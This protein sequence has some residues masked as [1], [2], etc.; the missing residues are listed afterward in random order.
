[1]AVVA[2][3]GVVALEYSSDSGSSYAAISGVTSFDW[4][5]INAEELD[6]TDFDS[7]DGMR[8]YVN[9]LKAAADGSIVLNYDPRDTTHMAL[10]SANGGA[11]IYLKAVMDDE[12][13]TFTA[14]VKG[15]STPAEVGGIL[16]AT[17]TIKLTGSPTYAATA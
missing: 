15:F 13:V 11:P 7:P 6:A 8:E 5:S 17:I 3:N 14:L 9:G 4:G 10:R 2:K 16:K 12:T 1:M